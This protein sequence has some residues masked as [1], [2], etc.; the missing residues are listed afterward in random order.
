[1]DDTLRASNKN[2]PPD[3]SQDADALAIRRAVHDLGSK[4][5]EARATARTYVLSA[6][7]IA[8]PIIV[9]EL[10]AHRKRSRQTAG[11]VALIVALIV[12]V[13][14]TLGIYLDKQW[15]VA[16]G[17]IA[18][19]IVLLVACMLFTR[20]AWYQEASKLLSKYGGDEVTQAMIECL[21]DVW[22]EEQP[23]LRA[24]IIHRLS[25]VK[26]E[27]AA[28]LQ[29]ETRE[30]IIAMV[31]MPDWSSP[32]CVDHV[33]IIARALTAVGATEAIP[34]LKGLNCA[35]LHGERREHLER[36]LSELVS[37]LEEIERREQLSGELLRM[38]EETVVALVRP[39][40]NGPPSEP[41]VLLQASKDDAPK[42]IRRKRG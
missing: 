32:V 20:P 6:G 1:M 25:T 3:H 4:N 16:G 22:G 15:L 30:R 38:P 37:H 17:N 12:L 14:P 23:R 11:Y 13:G 28:W 10:K 8:L 35:S 36:G 33:L 41:D 34:V 40:E 27:D 42:P 24:S 5:F 39:A 29:G 9:H 31:S 19:C 2:E 7:Q 18:A 21:T 26:E